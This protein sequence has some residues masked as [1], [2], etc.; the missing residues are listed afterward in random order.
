MGICGL[1]WVWWVPRGFGGFAWVSLGFLGFFRFFVVLKDI[2][3]QFGFFWVFVSICGFPVGLVGSPG[4]LWVFLGSLSFL[5][6]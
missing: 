2:L 1:S 5:E 6:F 3:R 4:F